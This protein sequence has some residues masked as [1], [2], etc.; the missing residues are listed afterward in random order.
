MPRPG[1]TANSTGNVVLNK[2]SRE[3]T[4]G[5][6]KGGAQ[7]MLLGAGLGMEDFDKAQVGISSVWWEGRWTASEDRWAVLMCSAG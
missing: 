7:A 2:Y 5:A 6:D 4:Q 1:S 3:V